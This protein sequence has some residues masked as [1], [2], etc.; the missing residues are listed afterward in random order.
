MLKAHA[1]ARRHGKE[2]A[3]YRWPSK[4]SEESG[5]ERRFPF[6]WRVGFHHALTLASADLHEGA[7]LTLAGGLKYD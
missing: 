6:V 7:S 2:Q 3:R 4:E 1:S 5:P